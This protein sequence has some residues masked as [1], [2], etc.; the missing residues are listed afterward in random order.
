MANET[1]LG[2]PVSDQS[3]GLTPVGG[4][5]NPLGHAVQVS[6]AHEILEKR[7]QQ[8]RKFHGYL[9]DFSSGFRCNIHAFNAFRLFG[10]FRGVHSRV[11]ETIFIFGQSE[12]L[13]FRGV[14][15]RASEVNKIEPAAPNPL[16]L[17]NLLPGKKWGRPQAAPLSSIS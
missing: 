9:P 5:H 7:T 1:G 13:L 8:G 10:L 15:S 14:H 6:F 12:R 16:I 2:Q 4:F 11:I 3:L 17:G